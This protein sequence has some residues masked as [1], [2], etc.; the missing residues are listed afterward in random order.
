[1]GGRVKLT[2]IAYYHTRTQVNGAASMRSRRPSWA[3]SPRVRPPHSMS[4]E[5]RVAGSEDNPSATVA[6][7]DEDVL[8]EI[9]PMT[10]RAEGVRRRAS[11][12]VISSRMPSDLPAVP[13]GQSTRSPS[14][15]GAEV[16]MTQGSP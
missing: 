16:G 1:M 2:I 3:Q 5:N 9:T 6:A 13:L 7:A 8:I 15:P 11:P 14:L 12:G 4:T 10:P